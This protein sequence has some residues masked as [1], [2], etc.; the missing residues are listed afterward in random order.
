MGDVN[1]WKQIRQRVEK[2]KEFELNGETLMHKW[3]SMLSQILDEFIDVKE[4][5]EKN[6]E[7]WRH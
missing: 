5:K 4:G 3:S 2:L 7:F 6:D 1:D